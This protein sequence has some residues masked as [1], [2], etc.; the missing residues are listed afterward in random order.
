[1]TNV[2]PKKNKVATI[3]FV[4]LFG[5]L[6]V[7]ALVFSCLG[8]ETVRPMVKDFAD[9]VAK[10]VN[11]FAKGTVDGGN[12]AWFRAVIRNLFGHFFLFMLLGVFADLSAARLLP[13]KKLPWL[14]SALVAFGACAVL[15]FLFEGLQMIPAL[16][17]PASWSHV[18]IDVGG[19]ALGVLLALLVATFVKVLKSE[20]ED[21]KK[22]K[23]QRL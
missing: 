22:K 9:W 13:F 8:E 5:V 1:M 18:G 21:E 15:A 12:Q 6:A 20:P 14:F 23:K 19:A 4:A 11:A 16:D 10:V 2:S 3:A 7:L 17:R